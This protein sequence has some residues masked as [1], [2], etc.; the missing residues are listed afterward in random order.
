MEG[1]IE[2]LAP[3]RDSRFLG[4]GPL[5]QLFNC[6]LAGV[7]D[8][9]KFGDDN[10]ELGFIEIRFK[11]PTQLFRVLLD[12]EGELAKLLPAVF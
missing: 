10:L 2:R 7:Y 8:R 9:E 3:F 4:G 6:G 5:V 1:N 11:C 12:K